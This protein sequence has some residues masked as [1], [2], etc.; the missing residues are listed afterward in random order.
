MIGIVSYFPKCRYTFPL[1]LQGGV[2]WPGGL[3]AGAGA[4]AGGPGQGLLEAGCPLLPDRQAAVSAQPG[5]GEPGRAA[6]PAALWV[7]RDCRM[8]R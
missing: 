4:P 1:L 2:P 6:Q 7:S 3:G 8:E 5:S